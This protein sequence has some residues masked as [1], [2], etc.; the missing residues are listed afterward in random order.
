MMFLFR[1]SFYHLSL[2]TAYLRTLGGKSQ[3]LTRD[4]IQRK[5]KRGDNNNQLANPADIES[6]C[7]KYGKRV[8]EWTPLAH[9][10][11]LS[12]FSGALV[13]PSSKGYSQESWIMRRRL[14]Q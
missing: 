9:Y 6:R 7:H 13:G 11:I 8:R 5:A 12:L 10:P 3:F 14:H 1:G 4:H 2:F